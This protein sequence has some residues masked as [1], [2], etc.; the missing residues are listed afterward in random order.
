MLAIMFGCYS[1]TLYN[2]PSKVHNE[3]YH[4]DKIDVVEVNAYLVD[5]EEGSAEAVQDA[6][7]LRHA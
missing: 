3:K 2:A 1:I 7:R 5:R 4:E 6:E